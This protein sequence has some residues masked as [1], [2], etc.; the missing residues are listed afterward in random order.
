MFLRVGACVCVGGGVV[1]GH[2]MVKPPEQT[3]KCALE[4][5]LPVIKMGDT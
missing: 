3:N 1:V 4:I 5:D 2:E